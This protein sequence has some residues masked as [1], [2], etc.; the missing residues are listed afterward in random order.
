MSYQE[1]KAKINNDWN[2]IINNPEITLI[3]LESNET[4]EDSYGN[5]LEY[6][7]KVFHVPDYN[8]YIRVAYS[9]YE[10]E[11]IYVNEVKPK[12][13]ISIVYENV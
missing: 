8:C 2:L 1:L 5:V 6:G 10:S 3:P 4:E 9:S 11:I 12:Q 7:S 13:K